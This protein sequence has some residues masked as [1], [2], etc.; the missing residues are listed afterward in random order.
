M[1]ARLKL[2]TELYD[3]NIIAALKEHLWWPDFS[4]DSAEAEQLF[5]EV[6][7]SIDDEDVLTFGNSKKYAITHAA[8]ESRGAISL[9]HQV[10][11]LRLLNSEL[12]LL[13][14]A[15]ETFVLQITEHASRNRKRITYVGP[16][17]I[18]ERKR[19]NSVIEGNTLATP[20][21]R[22]NHAR[23]HRRIEYWV[24]IGGTV[25]LVALLVATY[26]WA[27]RDFDNPRQTWFFSVLEKFIGSVAITTLMA[28]V[29]YR[30]YLASLRDHTINWSIPGEREQHR[31]NP[32][33]T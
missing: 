10:W 12:H 31:I 23:Q 26:P 11:V 27:F 15:C 32:H 20:Q 18:V 22:V 2:T 25:V 17:Q 6:E 7:D 3:E 19:K 30:S 1:R 8:S 9:E 13:R 14:L 21:D 28:F 16:V 5:K 4:Q 24:S 29:Q 33:G